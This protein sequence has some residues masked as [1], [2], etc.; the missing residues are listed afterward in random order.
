MKP[1]KPRNAIRFSFEHMNDEP[2]DPAVRR[3][4]LVF[5]VSLVLWVFP[6]LDSGAIGDF[7]AS[8]LAH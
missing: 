1:G 2:P 5:G 3:L 6:A 8:P 4:I 7:L